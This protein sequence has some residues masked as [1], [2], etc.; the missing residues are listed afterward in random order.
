MSN[1]KPGRTDY[2][3]I[4]FISGMLFIVF[5]A[6][7]PIVFFEIEFQS[8][9]LLI[10]GASFISAAITEIIVKIKGRSVHASVPER[11]ANPHYSMANFLTKL[12]QLAMTPS[13]E[14]GSSTVAP[15]LY[16]CDQTSANVVPGEAEV[17][18][19]WRNVPEE[20]PEDVLNTLRSILQ[21]SL[22]DGCQGTVELNVSNFVTYTGYEQKLA[23][24]FPG[25]V[26][27][28]DHPLVVKA[29]QI[30]ESFGLN[31]TVGG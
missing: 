23:R 17:F 27:P 1:R 15:T 19:D 25:F 26:I 14:F 29:K 10:T 31:V 5:W 18:L 24:E 12:K 22:E 28:V 20:D 4:S 16:H 2:F 11:G 6:S 21:D 8:L 3:M 7:E 30:L 13:E 9:L